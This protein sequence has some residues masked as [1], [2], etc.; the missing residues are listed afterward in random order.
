MNGIGK[1]GEEK[2]F[3]KVKHLFTQAP[4]L[5]C[6][7]PHKELVIR[8]DA[9]SRGLGAV[10]LQEGRPLAYANKALTDSETRYATTAK[11]MLAILLALEKSHKFACGLNVLVN[12]D[13][14][15]LE[16]ISKKLLDRAPKRLQGMLLRI[17]AYDIDV[18]YTPRHTQHLADMMSRSFIPVG[19]R[20]T[21]SEFE[22]INAVQFLPMRPEKIQKLQLENLKDETLQLLKATILE[23]WPEEPSKL[24][25]Q[26]SPY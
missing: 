4:I 20:G 13:H 10:L 14:K 7:S 2:A 21:P 25:P 24:L 18:Q 16:A 9:S 1:D 5:V 23:G 17:L 12:T 15:P 11:E 3:S 22:A 8:C 6:Y 19:N 26:L